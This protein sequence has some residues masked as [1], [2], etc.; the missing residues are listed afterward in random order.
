MEPPSAQRKPVAC[1]KKLNRGQVKSNAAVKN[2]AFVF[3]EAFKFGH[4]KAALASI[5]PTVAPLFI[6]A[7]RLHGQG[8][9]A[10]LVT[11]RIYLF[12]F[13]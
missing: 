2:P 9:D 4:V 3:R 7:S 12:V 5:Q 10:Y 6:T 11:S 1:E 13:V 8:C